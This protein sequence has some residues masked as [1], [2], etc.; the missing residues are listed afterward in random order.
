MGA[1]PS[2]LRAQ[3]ALIALLGV[4]LIPI[5]T[6][7]LR[8]LTHILTCQESAAAPVQHR[9]CPRTGRRRSTSS[10]SDR[11][12]PRRQRARPSVCGGLTLDVL[13]RQR[14]RRT[15]PTSPSPSPTTA[16]TAG[17]AR[18]SS[19]STTSTS[20]STSARSAPA[21]PPPTTFELR[22]DE[23][24]TYEIEGDL[25]DR[26]VAA[27]RGL[28]VGAGAV[29]RSSSPG[30]G[31]PGAGG[32]GMPGPSWPRICSSCWRAAICCANSV[33]WMPWN[34]P[35][36]QPTSCALAMR[37]SAPVGAVSGSNGQRQPGQ[38]LLQVGR[39][40]RRQ[41][42]DR[43]VVDLPQALAA[44]LVELGLAHL[45]EELLD[46]RADPHHLAGRLHRLVRR[47]GR[48]A[49][50]T[51]EGTR[52][53]ASSSVAEGSDMAANLSRRAHAPATPARS[54][55]SI[56]SGVSEPWRPTRT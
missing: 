48:S 23:G 6:S 50:G 25:L 9:R 55:T 41:L 1:M 44:R 29:G 37:S 34:R 38:L 19:S 10:T 22:L 12:Q 32:C 31:W 49:S 30:R 35:S 27:R 2:A 7:S 39:Q 43:G 8:G 15:G 17:A 24:S 45:L 16:S 36:S 46:H 52:T 40:R 5:G 51:T 4:L 21:R 53:S 54:G 20:R 14:A 33:A 42:G 18:C 56:S 11:A 28:Q 47:L 13:D 26:P 3:V